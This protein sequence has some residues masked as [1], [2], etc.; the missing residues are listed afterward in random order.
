M[1]K[2]AIMILSTRSK[3]AIK[4]A[5]AMTIAYA[6]SLWMGWDKPYWAG[7]AVAVVSLA[8]T[9]QSLN[10]GAMRMLGTLLTTVVALILIALFAQDR[11]LFMVFLS[12]YVGFCTYMMGGAKN[13]YFWHVCGFVVW[14]SVWP[15]APIQKRPSRPP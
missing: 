2:R 15:Q 3:E 10:K 12:L 4:T 1:L 13:Q 6:I 9:G 11:W 5:L 14:L 7:F 8:T